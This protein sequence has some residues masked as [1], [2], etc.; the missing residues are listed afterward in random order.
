MP[1]SI[2]TSLLIVSELP[3]K[4]NAISKSESNSKNCNGKYD[5]CHNV[6]IMTITVALTA[7]TR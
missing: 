7:A 4:M 5:P 3:K 1:K 2:K 6:N